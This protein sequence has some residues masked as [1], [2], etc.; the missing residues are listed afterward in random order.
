[1][2]KLPLFCLVLKAESIL[3]R[4]TRSEEVCASRTFRTAVVKQK[5]VATKKLFYAGAE[6]DA[7]CQSLISRHNGAVPLKRLSNRLINCFTGPTIARLKS[8]I[9]K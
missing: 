4:I 1:M 3:L 2:I 9:E 6:I 7:L 5:H 8:P